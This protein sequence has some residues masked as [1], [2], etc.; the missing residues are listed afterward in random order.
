MADTTATFPRDRLKAWFKNGCKPTEAHFA[1][2]LDS[3]VHRSDKIPASSVDGLEALLS[4]LRGLTRDEVEALIALHDAR[5]AAH[6]LGTAAD[7]EA[8]LGPPAASPA[9]VSSAPPV[10]FV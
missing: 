10:L 4:S 1:A 8:A 9:H 6:S 7:F 3:Y 5:P 2:A